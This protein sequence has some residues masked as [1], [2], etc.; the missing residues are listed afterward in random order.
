MPLIASYAMAVTLVAAWLAWRLL[1]LRARR[2]NRSVFGPW[3]VP[4]V[5]L[6]AFDPAFNAT[7]FGPGLDGEVHFIS[8]GDRP[9]VG[10]VSDLESWILSVLAKRRTRIFEFGTC[11]GKTTYHLAR[12]SPADARIV[13]LTLPPEG[14]GAYAA[15]DRDDKEHGEIALRESRFTE[16][17]YTG[18]EAAGKVEQL[19][20]D[21]KA[22]DDAPHAGSFDLIFVDGSHA[23]SYVVSDTE[24][25]LRM[26]RPGGIVLWHDYRPKVP[27]VF[28]HLNELS[29][30]LP[31][32][33]LARTSLVAY[34]KPG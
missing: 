9:A 32:V 19:Y 26:V 8:Q 28:R 20:G 11:T 14:H 27:G 7:E 1:S 6:G 31:L 18:T 21:S 10:G 15:S 30:R 2:K 17:L 5:A 16:F 29:K 12:N 33:H 13:T 25:A 3:P 34:R 22:L 24:K 23:H 4:T